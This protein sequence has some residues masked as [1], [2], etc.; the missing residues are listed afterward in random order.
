MALILSRRCAVLLSI[1]L[2]VGIV[3]PA[4]GAPSAQPAWEAEWFQKLSRFPA[5]QNDVVRE[6][7]VESLE[8]H[9]KA[10]P[11]HLD[12]WTGTLQVFRKSDSG[13]AVGGV[14]ALADLCGGTPHKIVF[15]SPVKRLKPE[16]WARRSLLKD[17]ILVEIHGRVVDS[18]LE[19]NPRYSAP[20]K[21]DEAEPGTP[22]PQTPLPSPNTN[23]VAQ[24]L[25]A[26]AAGED[27]TPQTAGASGAISVRGIL[28]GVAQLGINVREAI[29]SKFGGAEEISPD[30]AEVTPSVEASLPQSV[31]SRV[32]RRVPRPTSELADDIANRNPQL[33][34][35]IPEA[36]TIYVALE[37]LAPFDPGLRHAEDL[38]AV[39]QLSDSITNTATGILAPLQET[40]AVVQKNMSCDALLQAAQSADCA[41]APLRAKNL[42]F[43]CSDPR[44]SLFNREVLA[45]AQSFHA[46]EIAGISRAVAACRFDRDY[47]GFLTQTAVTID[48]F[49]DVLGRMHVDSQYLARCLPER[50]GAPNPMPPAFTTQPIRPPRDLEWGM[51]TEELAKRLSPDRKK[52]KQA[53]WEIAG[54]RGKVY[55][56][57]DSQGRLVVTSWSPNFWD[58]IYSGLH[59]KAPFTPVTRKYFNTGPGVTTRDLDAAVAQAEAKRMRDVSELQRFWAAATAGITEKYGPP[60]TSGTPKEVQLGEKVAN[61]WRDSEGAEIELRFE[62]STG[63]WY[64]VD[65]QY[66]SSQ[67]MAAAEKQSSDAF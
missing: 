26:G 65:L 42:A 17:G 39:A 16:T 36:V 7:I 13:D 47:S 44:G 9:A 1:T 19:R 14:I 55:F 22:L 63:G 32:F 64:T 23:E 57:F 67:H 37:D 38:A 50:I 11:Q 28:E 51:T 41:E 59:N 4:L 25:T 52:L 34:A 56:R 33:A 66:R 49:V 18:G 53:D 43:T 10:V 30:T 15:Y 29:A 45:A 35:R 60:H 48:D 62:R 40:M 3:R 12:G 31:L 58:P 24:A 5:A 46:S 61:I 21:H 2:S 54:S 6:E 8:S 20:A 27:T